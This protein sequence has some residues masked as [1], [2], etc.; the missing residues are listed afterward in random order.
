[1]RKNAGDHFPDFLNEIRMH[2]AI[3]FADSDRYLFPVAFDSK[4]FLLLRCLFD[5]YGNLL[6]K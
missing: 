2:K 3:D 1:M 4:R 5:S 6:L